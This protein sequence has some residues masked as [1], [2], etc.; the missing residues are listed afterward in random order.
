MCWVV[1]GRDDSESLD[2]CDQFVVV[3]GLVGCIS[4]SIIAIKV[5]DFVA[6][7]R[8]LALMSGLDLPL[9]RRLMKNPY[10]S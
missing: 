6:H 3:K 7:A 9:R 10:A 4:S 8:H 1:F 5:A 2:V